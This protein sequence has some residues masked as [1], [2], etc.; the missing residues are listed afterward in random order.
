MLVT[1]GATGIGAALTEGFV[2]QGARVAFIDI[3]RQAGT[4]LAERLAADAAHAPLFL[5][6]DL[7]DIEA[8]RDAVRRAAD[9]HGAV[10]VLIN[11]AARDD[12]HDLEAVTADSFDGNVAINLRPVFFA[13]QAVV[14]GMKAA[15]G[16]A[17][18][19]LASTCYLGHTERLPVYSAAKA[20]IVGLTQG[21]ARTL[22]RDAIR[23]NA[24]APG[25]VMTERQKALW[26]TKGAVEAKI[27]AQCLK[28]AMLPEDVVGPCLF[29][30]S[31]A[32]AMVTAQVLIADGGV[33]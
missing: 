6:A 28:R 15:G 8:L 10:T 19:N 4:A 30:A 27:E 24:L 21:L 25:W 13:I 20:G 1:G 31:S 32:S 14:P 26:V 18:V 16:G 17:I 11:N 29:L 23:I 22:G 3:D 7:R 9:A 33:A 12:R 2:A 5:E